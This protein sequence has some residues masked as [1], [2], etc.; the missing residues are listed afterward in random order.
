MTI[1]LKAAVMAGVGEVKTLIERQSGKIDEIESRL[2]PLEKATARKGVPIYGEPVNHGDPMLYSFLQ[3]GQ[4]PNETKDLSVTNDG[5]GVTVRGQWSDRIFEKILETSPVR[6][7]AN[8]MQTDSNELEVLVD[9][10][11][12][13]SS[14]VGELVTRDE[15]TTSYLTRHKIPVFE[16]YAYPMATLQMLEDSQFNVE[17]WLQSKLFA[18]FSR[19]EAAA[20]INGDGEGKPRGLL[21]YGIAA[22]SDF[23]WAADPA[24]YVI[25]AHFTAEPGDIVS[26]EVLFDVVDSLKSAYLS[27]ASW[28]MT[29]AMRNKI[30]KLKDQE[31]R[32]LFEPSLQAGTPDRLLGYPVFLAEDMPALDVDVVGAL[33]GNFREAYTIVDRLGITVQRD[34]VT[35]P[36]WVKYY[37]R[38]RVGGALTNPE[39]VKALVLGAV[40]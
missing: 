17:N 1:E 14:W 19:Q 29:R 25:G 18:R 2:L 11:E 27:G 3:K 16:H 20:F 37:A 10:D 9:R 35:K 23:A 5:Q 40:S 26:P 7:V 24:D 13:G 30:R 12:P 15:T 21:D 32:Y 31:N 38:R 4:M 22:E 39:A 34:T 8:L 33:F 28:M 36:G 6:A